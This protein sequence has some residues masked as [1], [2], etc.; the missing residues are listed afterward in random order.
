MI[1]KDPQQLLPRHMQ[2]EWGTSNMVLEIPPHGIPLHLKSIEKLFEK[3]KSEEHPVAFKPSL[4]VT[5]ELGLSPSYPTLAY[6][7]PQKPSS[8][9][10]EQNQISP[11]FHNG[12]QHASNISDFF[13]FI[14]QTDVDEHLHY[15]VDYY[16]I[17]IKPSYVRVVVGNTCNLKCIMCPYHST[18]LKSNHTTDFFKRSQ[19]MS[20]QMMERLAKDCG[21]AKIM[22]VIGNIEEPMLHP[23]IVDFIQLC[24]WHGVPAVHMTT[25]GQLL[26]EK[27]SKALLEAGLTSID[28]S[29]DAADPDTYLK[30]RGADLKR[31]ESNV[32]NFLKLR[33]Q[34]NISCYV[35]TSFVR[36]QN[37]S[38]AEEQRFREYWL[39]EAD[40]VFINNVAQYQEG[41][42]HTDRTNHAVQ[43]LI[44]HYLQ[45]A[46][47]RWPCLFPFT[48][49]TV[50]PD[51]RIYYCVETLFRLGFDKNIQ[52]LG[53][54]KQQ[55]LQEIWHG[56]PFKQL[57][58]DLILNQLEARPVCKNCEL[59]MA[60]VTSK[61]SQ[62]GL[63][64]TTTTITEIYQKPSF[65]GKC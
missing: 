9:W 38:L 15:F 23:K 13:N 2:V 41:N 47:G 35:R 61:T 33:D 40:G 28:I 42:T 50:L 19:M 43:A 53:D 16:G 58:Q 63:D 20:L 14:S 25:N 29:I 36:N 27:H 17:A 62:I 3:A 12:L 11:S 30:V 24:R 26:D 22:V 55:T 56:G 5:S 21:E 39:A 4:P 51:G 65:K 64:I 48:E 34:F 46:K 37:V 31:V 1:I 6:L 10:N 8:S 60:Q 59:W 54:Y 44:Q 57:R 45:K 49:M 7:Y 18:L 32:L 52:S